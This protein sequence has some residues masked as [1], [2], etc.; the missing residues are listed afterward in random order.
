MAAVGTF[1]RRVSVATQTKSGG[2]L[3]ARCAVEDDF[4][5]F[6]VLLEAR[7]GVVTGVR[8]DARRSPNSLCEAAGHQLHKLV[9]MALDPASAAVLKQTDQ[10]QQCT[11][12]LD[13]AGLGVAAMACRRPQRTYEI[14]VPDR[15]GGHT[16]ATLWVD[17][18]PMLIWRV[19]GM[20]IEGPAPYEGRSM[21][22]GFTQFTA[23][24]GVGEA[25]A[26]LVLRRALFV[27]QGRAMD[28]DAIGDRGPVGGCW[29]WQPDR[30][31]QLRRLPEN[32]R[33]FS[34]SAQTALADD[35]EWLEFRA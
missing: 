26:A 24:L 1:R 31:S 32:R 7:D 28:L 17:G 20:T 18:E 5:H 11:H 2:Q 23:S 12:Q 27:S 22:A 16:T 30:I 9:G 35:A 19:M 3:E 8:T 13:L 6:R 33:H 10:F 14:A 34:D 29:A 25:E 15:E 21:G 4:H